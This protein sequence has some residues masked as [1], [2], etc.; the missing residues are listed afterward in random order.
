MSKS[1]SSN[2]VLGNEEN[3]PDIR[4]PDV[5]EIQ[6]A[7]PVRFPDFADG[8]GTTITQD[9]LGTT[10]TGIVIAAVT[11]RLIN[12]DLTCCKRNYLLRERSIVS[13]AFD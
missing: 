8:V 9:E 1:Q 5:A 7:K 11:G 12:T 2:E 4:Y 6:K 3:E 13:V 10:S